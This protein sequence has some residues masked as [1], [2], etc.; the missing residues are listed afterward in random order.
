MILAMKQLTL[1]CMTVERKKALKALAQLG[2]VHVKATVRDTEAI[3]TATAQVAFVEQALRV[4]DVAKKNGAFAFKPEAASPVNGM[5]LPALLKCAK[6]L[7]VPTSAEDVNRFAEV[8]TRLRE[9]AMVLQQGLRRYAPFGAVDPATMA[10]LSAEGLPVRLFKLPVVALADLP[11]AAFVFGEE[12]GFCY[13]AMIGDEALPTG[14]E[15]MPL[16]ERSTAEMTKLLDEAT[17]LADRL[18]S[19]LAMIA[20]SC[21]SN[22]LA[23]LAKTQHNRRYTEVS[24]NLLAMDEV[25][26]LSGYLPERQCEALTACAHQ[27]GWGIVLSDPATDDPDVPVCLEPPKGF[28]SIGTLFSGLGILPGYTEGDISIPFYTFFSFFFAML[29]GDAGYGAIMLAGVLAA[30]WKL[31]K[32]EAARPVLTIFTVFSCSAIL[33]G[34]LSGTYFGIA[35]DALPALLRDIPTVA[36]LGND[37]NIM[38]L[39]FLVGALH[40]SVARVWNAILLLPNIKALGEIGWLGVTWSMFMIVSGIV[41]SWFTQPE[42]VWWFLGGSVGIILIPMITDIRNEGV[43]IGMLP[44]NVISAMGDIISYVRLFAV[45]LAS[46]KVAENFNMMALNLELPF[47]ARIIAI[48]L[49]LLLGH[50][51]NLAMGALSILVHAVRLN[52]LEFSNAKGVT[53]GGIPYNPFKQPQQ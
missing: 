34:I 44:L 6:K 43:N 7:S 2:C 20:D 45:G 35:K 48:A 13:G 41:V 26:V 38:F 1:F 9:E 5:D 51:L 30:A 12:A 19:H 33:W 53:W 3:R 40:I 16:P 28:K 17:Q 22:L 8:I 10:T 14:A 18:V 47:V 32:Q 36:W 25:A 31:W 21:R 50:G 23:A 49:I 37:N 15:A 24:E 27:E 46:V 11:K 52:T 39:C 29:I 4:L 42:W